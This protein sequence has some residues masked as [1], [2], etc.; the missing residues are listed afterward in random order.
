MPHEE[1]GYVRDEAHAKEILEQGGTLWRDPVWGDK[2]GNFMEVIDPGP[3][4]YTIVRKWPN[5]A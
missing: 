2:G 4:Q 3:L 5:D 1:T